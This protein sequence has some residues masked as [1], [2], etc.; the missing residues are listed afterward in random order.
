MT[1]RAREAIKEA[2]V[3]RL[4]NELAVFNE[5]DEAL[6]FTAIVPTEFIVASAQKHSHDL[7]LGYYSV[8]SNAMALRHG[9]T[10]I[11]RVGEQLRA[12]GRIR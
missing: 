9:E 8:H 12:S 4:E 5:S 1:L 10:E 6:D 7:V 3:T 11:A 2:D